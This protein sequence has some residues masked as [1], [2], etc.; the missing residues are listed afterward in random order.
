MK[1]LEDA[2]AIANEA[3]EQGRAE[4]AKE[5]ARMVRE[6]GQAIDSYSNQ[7]ISEELERL[8]LSIEKGGKK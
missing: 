6:V 5:H 3:M 7:A 1:L 8:A 4:A 2:V